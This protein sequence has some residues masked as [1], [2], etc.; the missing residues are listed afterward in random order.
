MISPRPSSVSLA[1]LYRWLDRYGDFAAGVAAGRARVADLGRRSRYQRA[2]GCKYLAERVFHFRGRAPVVAR[3]RKRILADPKAALCWLRARRPDEWR[4]SSEVAAKNRRR[5]AL[6]ALHISLHLVLSQRGAPDALCDSHNP[7]RTNSLGDRF[8]IAKMLGELL[9]LD[10]SMASILKMILQG[11]AGSA[12]SDTPV[13]S[14]K[15]PDTIRFTCDPTGQRSARPEILDQVVAV[16]REDLPRKGHGRAVA[17]GPALDLQAWRHASR[18]GG[19]A[20]W[21]RWRRPR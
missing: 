14:Q 9:A 2:I 7:C 21:R 17:P 20:R 11:K 13:G 19:A 10:P 4:V 15:S 1:T 3:Y 16:A 8:S 5:A 18:Y 6:E 12:K